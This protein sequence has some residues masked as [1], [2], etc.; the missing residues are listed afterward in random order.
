MTV[1]NSVATWTL[2]MPQG[3]LEEYTFTFL[4]PGPFSTIPYPISGA[5]WQYVVRPAPTD[6]SAPL[7]DI[8]TASTS[9]G[10]ITVT[11][12]ATLSQV[13]LT[14]LPA[15]TQPLAPGTYYH[16][17]WMNPDTNAAYAW[18]TGLLQ[19]EGNPQPS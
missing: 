12:T 9:E 4:Q 14:I 16:T 10:Q 2:Q 19:I 18:L 15:A 13:L 5:T 1:S 17:L 7:I 8:T 6:E 3:S 11:S